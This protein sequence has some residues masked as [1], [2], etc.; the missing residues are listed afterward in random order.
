MPAGLFTFIFSHLTCF[1]PKKLISKECDKQLAGCLGTDRML[2]M[3]AKVLLGG[4]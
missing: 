1:Y 2:W 4:C 3:V